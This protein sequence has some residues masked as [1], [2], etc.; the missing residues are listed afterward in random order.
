MIAWAID[1]LIAATLLML[2]VLAVRAPVARLFGAGWAYA[3]WLLPLLRIAMPPLDLF[4]PEVAAALPDYT[5]IVLPAAAAAAASTAPAAAAATEGTQIMPLLLALWGGGAAVFMLWQQSAYS[6]FLMSLGGHGRPASPPV[7]GGIKVIESESVD[8]PLA[9]GLLRR[10]IVVPLDFLERY[11]AEE[12]A[13]ALDHE[14]IHHRRLDIF[15]NYAALAMLAAM[16]F[17]PVAWAAFR[18][19]R[20]DQELS[21]DAAVTRRAPQRR[22][23]YA[24]ALI[25][26]ASRPGAVAACPLNS[27]DQLKRRLKMLKEHRASRART[28]GGAAAVAVLLA[29]GLA[30]SSPGFAREEAPARATIR[31]IVLKAAANQAP[32][33]TKEEIDTLV[34]RC[35]SSDE[36]RD[37]SK[38]GVIV[39]DNGKAVDDPEVK[40]IVGKALERAQTQVRS[41][42]LSAE[43]AERITDAAI[44]RAVRIEPVE[45]ERHMK[46]A[47]EALEA[48]RVTLASSDFRKTRAIAMESALAGARV[49]V[50]RGR[51]APE[52]LADIETALAEAR[53]EMD[54]E[55]ADQMDILHEQL[56]E[57]MEGL[58]VEI[59]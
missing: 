31:P 53:A 50:A 37:R 15:W 38:R 10:R 14:L 51:L 41:A 44:E 39:C 26:S 25:K 7:H 32:I 33:I 34:E 23:D 59:D 13:L 49:S 29:G 11:S 16:W 55:F 2:L 58:K 27:A 48:A 1:T 56:S 22:H 30:L 45:M 28:L 18:A 35:A 43:Q 8:G 46:H 54:E 6:A 19:F 47:R 3:L 12:R 4:S 40:R 21:C 5:I 42:Q 57:E 36:A 20:A 9:V 24:R 17:S 52:L